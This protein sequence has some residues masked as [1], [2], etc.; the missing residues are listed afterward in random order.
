VDWKKVEEVMPYDDELCWIYRPSLNGK[1]L[2]FLGK[3]NYI[4]CKPGWYDILGNFHPRDQITHWKK[5][6]YPQPPRS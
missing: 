4:M 6:Q 3:Y 1:P 5:I 2:T